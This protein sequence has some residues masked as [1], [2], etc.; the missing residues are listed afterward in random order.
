M[1]R[2]H[3]RRNALDTSPKRQDNYEFAGAMMEI[4]D[5][6]IIFWIVI[7]GLGIF[8]FMM[9]FFVAVEGPFLTYTE[10]HERWVRRNRPTTKFALFIHPYSKLLDYFFY[11]LGHIPAPI[12]SILVLILGITRGETS[13]PQQQQS[14]KENQTPRQ[15]AYEAIQAKLGNAAFAE[16][17]VGYAR[18]LLHAVEHITDAEADEFVSDVTRTY[19]R[20]INDL[21]KYVRNGP[22]TVP[23]QDIV[24]GMNLKRPAD[25][26]FGG[27]F[28]LWKSRLFQST[29]DQ[30]NQNWQQMKEDVEA[31][32]YERFTDQYFQ[33]ELHHT[34][35]ESLYY[36]D[37]PIRFPQLSRFEGTAICMPQGSGKT[38]LLSVLLED[39][40]KQV[41][42]GKASIIIFDAK[43]EFSK[44]VRQLKRFAPGQPLHGKLVLVE[45]EL[46]LAL[47]PINLGFSTA[48]TIELIQYMFSEL[49]DIETTSTQAQLLTYVL[50][51][52]S[53]IPNATIHTAKDI[54][55]G[56]WIKYQMFINGLPERYLQFFRDHWN[57][58]QFRER[59]EEVWRRLD[60]LTMH[61]EYL[62]QMFDAPFTK[63][64]LATEMDAGKVIIIDNSISK[65]TRN[66]ARYFSRFFFALILQAANAR[67]KLSEHDK[68]PTYVY[69]DE[70]QEVIETDDNAARLLYECRSQ[71]I[72]M[73][74]SYH[75]LA[76][77]ESK[78]VRD[79]LTACAIKITL[80]SNKDRVPEQGF[81]NVFMQ[82]HTK[83]AGITVKA[84]FR[85]V[86]DNKKW[87]KMSWSELEQIRKDMKAKYGPDSNPISPNPV[88]P[89]RPITTP[90]PQTKETWIEHFAPDDT[91]PKKRK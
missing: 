81:F 84:D 46:G 32:L 48:H 67:E 38:N 24:K 77:I 89:K 28:A 58:R 15:R 4:P 62:A 86:D 49:L 16:D 68:M 53:V 56:G 3:F 1:E 13:T 71:K 60:K 59:R 14:T 87:P 47:N 26:P 19:T 40:L 65:L 41:E 54:L 57:D 7:A 18:H 12:T 50:Y 36:A 63:L 88:V 70:A 80:P 52:C 37:A 43:G 20:F 10:F 21:P 33:Q 45:P 74:F 69:L 35:F 83:E 8:A 5:F 66:G 90:T 17:F 39:D 91:A 2:L 22:F 9:S 85:P 6:Y 29:Y 23:L 31:E 51:A 75:S 42:R 72:A 27:L 73:M 44:Q 55:H 76:E 82:R 11:I 78:R 30:Y 34:I 25:D 79:A 61:N 64:N